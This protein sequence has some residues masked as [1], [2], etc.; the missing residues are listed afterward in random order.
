MAADK[1]VQME[2]VLLIDF[3]NVQN[4]N[5]EQIEKFDYRIYVF[6]GESQNKIPFDLVK[7]A[8]KLGGKLKW[9]K[10]D[11]NGA[12][13]LDF[14]IAY[15]LGNQIEKDRNNEYVILSK[16]KGFDPL[17]KF[18]TKKNVKCRRINSIIEIAPTRKS[19]SH[20]EEYRKVLE[21]LKKIDKAKKPRRRNTLKQH[22]KSLLGKTLT[23]EICNEIIDQLFIEGIV[24][25][26]NGK[27]I[28]EL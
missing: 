20:N 9:I 10:I 7:A 5:L 3:E 25:E 18:I 12:N 2:K 24:S 19:D 11:G 16:D 6:I 28:Y 15:F 23:D 21:N 8:Q 13:A 17:V 22:V 1:G 26:E 4:I 27:L 14:H